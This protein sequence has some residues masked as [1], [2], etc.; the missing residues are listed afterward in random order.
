MPGNSWLSHVRLE[1]QAY[2]REAFQADPPDEEIVLL[3]PPPQV[4]PLTLAALT[5][6]DYALIPVEAS[7]L[8]LKGLATLWETLRAVRE[9]QNPRL[10]V[11]GIF[12]VRVEPHTKQGRAVLDELRKRFPRETLQAYIRKTVRLSEAPSWGLPITM[13]DA[14]SPGAWDYRALADEI[15]HRLSRR[16]RHGR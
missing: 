8:G 1:E 4:G 13:L 6:A 16:G 3:D 9:E 12:A 14:S 7:P 2:L 5:A 11:L 10:R 15:E